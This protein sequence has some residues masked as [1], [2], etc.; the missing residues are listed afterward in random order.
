MSYDP[1]SIDAK[2]QVLLRDSIGEM[3]LH[4]YSF[5]KKTNKYNNSDHKRLIKNKITKRRKK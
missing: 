2:K 1:D 5:E 4:K 3:M